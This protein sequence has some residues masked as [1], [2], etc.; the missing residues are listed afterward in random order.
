VLPGL[1]FFFCSSCPPLCLRFFCPSKKK[2]DQLD[3]K[4]LWM[5]GERMYGERMYGERMYGE[6]VC[7]ELQYK[8][9]LLMAAANSQ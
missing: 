6:R 1:I 8:L 2:P 4:A 5:Y 7:G 3:T 9:L